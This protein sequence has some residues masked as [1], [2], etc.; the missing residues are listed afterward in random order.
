MASNRLRLNSTKTELIWL[1]AA[2]YVQCCPAGPLLIAGTSI[3]PSVEVRDLGVKLDS[4]LSL[5]AH[6]SSV[7]SVCYFHLRQLRLV[8]RTLTVDA[9][10]SL[11]RALIHSRLDYCNGILANAPLG[12]VAPLQSVMRSAARVVLRIPSRGSITQLMRERLH[13][14]PIQQRVKFKQCTLAFKC[15]NGLAPAYLSR[16]CTALSSVPGHPATRS[17]VAGHLLVPTINMST[18]TVGRR[19]FYYACPAAWNTLPPTITDSSLTCQTFR[20]RSK[21]FLFCAN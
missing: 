9:A 18:V 3:T 8:R 1:G 12:L 13:W 17:A 11:V 5:Q 2:R 6:V 19:G 7:V 21:T 10:H 4:T 15:V 16:M 20:R 14:L